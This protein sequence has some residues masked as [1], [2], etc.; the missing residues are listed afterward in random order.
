MIDKYVWAGGRV[1]IVP[2]AF[3]ATLVFR[4]IAAPPF[5][6]LVASLSDDAVYP[7]PTSPPDLFMD[8]L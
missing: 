6:C 4:F 2:G 1:K 8:V 3:C 5:S 7:L